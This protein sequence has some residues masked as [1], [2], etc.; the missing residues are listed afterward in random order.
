VNADPSWALWEHKQPKLQ[1]FC[2][3][4]AKH[5]TLNVTLLPGVRFRCATA[6]KGRLRPRRRL[7]RRVFS[8][9]TIGEAALRGSSTFF[10]GAVSLIYAWRSESLSVPEAA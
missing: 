8:A 4:V 10:R 9:I 6:G 2:S 7:L 1:V 5:S 3:L